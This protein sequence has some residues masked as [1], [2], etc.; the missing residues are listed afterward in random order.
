[1]RGYITQGLATSD[2]LPRILARRLGR[3]GALDR[4]RPK[5]IQ[6]SE[7]NEISGDAFRFSVRICDRVGAQFSAND[8]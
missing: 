6:T 3:P 5:E 2:G 1:M 8:S 7:Y 4:E